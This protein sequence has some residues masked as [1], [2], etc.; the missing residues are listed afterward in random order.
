MSPRISSGVGSPE[1]MAAF[2]PARFV[3]QSGQL[4]RHGRRGRRRQA[5]LILGPV[6]AVAS[7]ASIVLAA[8]GASAAPA[9]TPSAPPPVT[10]LTSGPGA[11][12]GG[13]IF[14]SPFG[15]AATYLNG[16]EIWP[17]WRA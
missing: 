14:I 9:D 15:D 3:P 13:D 11:A 7:V 12:R 10:I 6:A 17:T 8:G 16:P 2:S 4:A 1:R 5:R